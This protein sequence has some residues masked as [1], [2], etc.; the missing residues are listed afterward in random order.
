[1]NKVEIVGNAHFDRRRQVAFDLREQGARPLDQGQGVP[2]RRRLH[3]D[4]Y[5]VLAVHLDARGPALRRQIDL[6]DV[7]QPHQ[8]AALRLDHHPFELA[9]IGEPGIG[10]DVGY[11]EIAFRLARCGLE[12]VGL[13]RRGNVV[14]RDPARRHP[15]RIEPQPHR[16]GLAAE[17]VGRS[18]AGDGD[19]QRLDHAGQII[20]DPGARQ[21]IAGKADIH[22]R[23][24]LSGGLGDDRVLGAGRQQVFDLLDLGHHLGQRLA[25][26]EIEPDVGDDRAGPL[27][28]RRR[29]IIHTLGRGD[30]LLERGR[31]ETLQETGRGAGIECRDRDRR[32]RQFRKLP[33]RQ[34]EH[35]AQ[36]D[37][38]DQEAD[39][40]RQHRASDKKIGERHRSAASFSSGSDAPAA[41]VPDCR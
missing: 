9:D 25:R 16:E 7:L 11:R 19:E 38:Q 41:A 22:D 29:Q 27:H 20:G 34:V 2:G 33:D 5:R 8:G 40:E 10:A 37:Q 26:I 17:D 15:H 6:G 32:V 35:C 12:V 36:P 21:F 24:G 13:D 3:A 39:D 14:G 4:E 18:D 1:M 31:D 28:Q 30:R 23:G